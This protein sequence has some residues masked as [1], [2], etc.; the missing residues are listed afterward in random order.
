MTH[1]DGKLFILKT[2]RADLL[3]RNDDDFPISILQVEKTHEPL[4]RKY[5]LPKTTTDVE[6][7]VHGFAIHMSNKAQRH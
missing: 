3:E 2:L 7:Y 4:L 5:Y 6:K 1:D